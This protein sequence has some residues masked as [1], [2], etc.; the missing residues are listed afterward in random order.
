MVVHAGKKLF[1]FRKIN[2][3]GFILKYYT[4]NETVLPANTST[5]F[6]A[7]TIFALSMRSAFGVRFTQAIPE[8]ISSLS[9]IIIKQRLS[10]ALRCFL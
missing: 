4:V 9:A 1:L 5:R 7:V 2:L 3:I 8:A 6:A 10:L